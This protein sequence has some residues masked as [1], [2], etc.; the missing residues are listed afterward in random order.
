MHLSLGISFSKKNYKMFSYVCKTNKYSI[1]LLRRLFLIQVCN[2][3][4]SNTRMFSA[5]IIAAELLCLYFKFSKLFS[6]KSHPE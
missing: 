4:W 3:Y 2:F 6:D 1:V 5:C